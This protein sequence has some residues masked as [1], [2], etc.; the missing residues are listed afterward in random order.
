[1]NKSDDT[2]GTVDSAPAPD[3]LIERAWKHIAKWTTQD[4]R[5][6]VDCA[7]S[8][9]LD[10][11]AEA[12]TALAAREQEIATCHETLS[13]DVASMQRAIELIEL[14]VAEIATLRDALREWTVRYVD[15]SPVLKKMH[16][17]QCEQWWAV[18]ADEN[19]KPGC[20]AALAALQET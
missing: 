18:D 1:M 8:D 7:D 2:G 12:A 19:H 6:Y 14:Q 16:C 10:L 20:L 9:S 11:L 17:Y 3:T 5:Q 4:G 13:K 15:V